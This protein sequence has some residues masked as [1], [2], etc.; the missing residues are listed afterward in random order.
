M[1]LATTALAVPADLNSLSWIAGRWQGQLPWGMIEEIWSP[2]SGGVMMG[3]FRMENNGKAS[4]YEFMTL[5]QTSTGVSL[6]LRHFNG[7]FTAR[8]EKDKP[9]DF[10]LTGISG[11]EATFFVDEG[12]AKVTLVYRKTGADSME[13]DFRKVPTEGKPQEL[14][15][16]YRR[17]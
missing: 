2:V 3:M 11:P 16:P 1:L 14:K 9:V 4:L 8:E 6:K 7:A 15:F 5:E 17:K 10:S 12:T 13:V